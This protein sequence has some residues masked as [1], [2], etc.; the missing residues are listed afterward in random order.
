MEPL[1][2]GYAQAIFQRLHGLLLLAYPR[3]FR[4][5]Y[6]AEM[7]LTFR[8]AYREALCERDL[9]GVMRFL[10]D[11]F[12][13]VVKTVCAEQARIWKQRG[14][15]ALA[16][17]AQ[18]RL[19]VAL[20]FTLDIAQRTDIGCTRTSNEDNLISLVPVDDRLLRAGRAV[21]GC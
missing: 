16:S 10:G 18:P 2:V 19:A 6:A 12:I 4:E 21:C 3:A 13:D 11:C 1:P 9:A 7:L 5:E 8:D 20:P 15:L 17:R 14:K